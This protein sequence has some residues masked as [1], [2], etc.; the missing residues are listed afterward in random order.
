MGI[1]SAPVAYGATETIFP[2]HNDYDAC[3]NTW[4]SFLERSGTVPSCSRMYWYCT[5]GVAQLAAY[6]YRRMPPGP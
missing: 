4:R 5:A 1:P 6:N 3:T 2:N